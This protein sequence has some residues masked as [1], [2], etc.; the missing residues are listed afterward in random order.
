MTTSKSSE[1]QICLTKKFSYESYASDPKNLPIKLKSLYPKFLVRRLW[2]ITSALQLLMNVARKNIA[3]ALCIDEDM[4][5]YFHFQHSCTTLTAGY[6]YLW[7]CW[8]FCH[9]H[10]CRLKSVLRP[11]TR[12]LHLPIHFHSTIRIKQSQSTHPFIREENNKR[13]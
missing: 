4:I 8:L 3:R 9:L 2:F 6:S 10:S 5:I 1:A 12:P 7:L 13:Q 11:T